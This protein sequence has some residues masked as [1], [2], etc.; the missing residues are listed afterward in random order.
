MSVEF[1]KERYGSKGLFVAKRQQKQ[2]SF[3]TQSK[4]QDDISQSQLQLWA[5]KKYA[6]DDYFS[7]W[8]KNIFKE[9]NFITFYKYMRY[10]LPSA[11]LVNDEIMPQLRRIFTAEDAY[12]RYTRNGVP[13]AAPEELEND[14]FIQE[15]FNAY[16]FEHNSIILTDLKG[17]NQPFREFIEIDKVIAID[18]EYDYIEKVAFIADMEMEDGEEIEGYLY[19]DDK[20][21]IF[22]DKDYNEIRYTAHDL[23][24][25]PADFVSP[26]PFSCDEEET[27]RKSIFSYTRE[28]MEEYVFLHTL[29]KMTE[30]NGAI[31]VTTMLQS[32]QTNNPS[33]KDKKGLPMQPMA[34]YELGGQQAY[35]FSTTSANQESELQTGTIIKVSPIKD[36]NGK[37]DMSI[38][39]DYMKFHYIPTEC[40]EYMRKRINEVKDDIIASVVG[41]F[42]DNVDVAKNS[43][44][45]FTGLTHKQDNLQRLAANLSKT[46]TKSDY[47]FMAMAYGKDNVSV[48]IFF[49]TDFFLESVDSLY[50]LFDKSPNPLESRSILERVNKNKYRNNPAMA[51]RTA[52]LYKLL[53]F[54]NNKDFL[55]SIEQNLVDEVTK[56][57]QLRFNYWIDMFEAEYGDIVAFWDENVSSSEKQKIVLITNLITSQIKV[58][59]DE[60]KANRTPTSV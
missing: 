38:I 35:T 7:T 13:I 3:F 23:G 32:K 47:K 29:L 26:E 20:A 45:I 10:P 9:D 40:L 46:I 50:D 48:D 52:I 58:K 18:A 6:T 51:K 55:V 57:L 1:V 54:A 56:D 27:V 28:Q 14:K 37:L 41:Q 5:Q 60:S 34:A 39:T 16:L 21:Y 22:Y 8:I 33:G 2:L 30:P 44:Q 17:I 11:R 15:V 25:C 19:V 42:K 24:E 53:P 36:A 49:G 59:L 31:P 43:D 12:R 4:V